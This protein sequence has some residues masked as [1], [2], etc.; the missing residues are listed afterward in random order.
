MDEFKKIFEH[1]APTIART[2]LAALTEQGKF[3]LQCW[4]TVERRDVFVYDEREL[5]ENF[6]NRDFIKNKS[7]VS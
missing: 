1:L 7:D 4:W 2:D 5:K 3:F 6:C